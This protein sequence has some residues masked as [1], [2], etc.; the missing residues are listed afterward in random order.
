ALA[1]MM[2][3]THTLK[4]AAGTVGLASVVDLSHRL[5][6]GLACI[7]DG[8][9]TWTTQTGDR[10]VEIVDGLLGVID[11]SASADGGAPESAALRRMLDELATGRSQSLKDAPLVEQA[12]DGVPRG[13]S[14]G[15]SSRAF[16]A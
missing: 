4:G 14:D 10:L 3:V 15:D 1:E 6:T 7:R 13:S 2:R 8:A 16:A 5:E 11:A 12:S 9:V